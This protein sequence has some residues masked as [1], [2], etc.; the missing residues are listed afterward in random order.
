MRKDSL[1]LLFR[2]TV[3]AGFHTT[4]LPSPFL[5]LT[6]F[7]TLCKYAVTIACSLLAEFDKDFRK[8]ERI[9]CLRDRTKSLLFFSDGYSCFRPPFVG[10]KKRCLSRLAPACRNR[11]IRTGSK[12]SINNSPP[13][14]SVTWPREPRRAPETF[15]Q[16]L[17]ISAAGMRRFRRPSCARQVNRFLNCP[18]S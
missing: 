2:Q 14:T 6:P 17:A 16:A 1:K 12:N 7:V 3:S 15:L 11:S 9:V 8:I 10:R 4:V 18:P 5:L 13:R